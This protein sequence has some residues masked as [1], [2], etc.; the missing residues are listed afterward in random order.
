MKPDDFFISALGIEQPWFIKEIDF[1]KP[2]GE[3]HVHVDYANGSSFKYK[4]ED[5]GEIGEYKTYDSKVKK[6]RHMNFFQ[7]RCYIHARVP[8]V[9]L[10]N[11]KIRLVKAPWEGISSHFTMVFEALLIQLVKAMT[12]H[13]V[14]QMTGVYDNKIWKLLKDYSETCRE[15]SDYSDVK[16][17]GVDET[18]ARRGHDYVTVFVDLVKKRQFL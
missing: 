17:I 11:R 18:A 1:N 14:A 4:D 13:Q 7:Y 10:G 8:R 16:E 6:W 15:M 3:F 9:N 12:V 2:K 5:S